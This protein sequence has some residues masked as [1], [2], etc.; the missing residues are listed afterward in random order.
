MTE[1]GQ[2]WAGGVQIERSGGGDVLLRRC[3]LHPAVTLEVARLRL[4]TAGEGYDAPQQSLQRLRGWAREVKAVVHEEGLNRWLLSVLAAQPHPL[5]EHME[6]RFSAGHVRLGVCL[7]ATNEQPPLL[8]S[9]D[10][11]PS[12]AG[13]GGDLW[14]VRVGGLRCWGLVDEVPAR[15]L[16][17]VLVSFGERFDPVTPPWQ[18]RA[19]CG[20]RWSEPQA[21]WAVSIA[22][23]L[24]LTFFVPLGWKLP[25]VDARARWVAEPGQGAL[26]LRL[27]ERGEDVDQWGGVSALAH[28]Q[29]LSLMADVDAA[30]RAGEQQRAA[31]MLADLRAQPGMER[32]SSLI[33][34]LSYIALAA[35][36][37]PRLEQLQSLLSQ[38][39]LAPAERAYWDGLLALRRR[40]LDHPLR[41]A[42]AARALRQSLLH[43]DPASLDRLY[44]LLTLA[45]LERQEHPQR[46]VAS[47]REALRD[48]PDH[49]LALRALGA[50]YASMG[51]AALLAE[52]QRRLLTLSIPGSAPWRAL[53]LSL[54]LALEDQS[55]RDWRAATQIYQALLDADPRDLDAAA[56][57]VRCL[58]A[59]GQRDAA[60]QACM[61]AAQ[62]A[63]DQPLRAA[64]LFAQAARLWL[65]VATPSAYEQA[66]IAC[67]RALSFDPDLDDA[68]RCMIDLLFDREQFEDCLLQLQRLRSSLQRRLSAA[69]AEVRARLR[70][71]LADVLRTM[72]QILLQCGREPQATASCREL[73]ALSPLDGFGLSTLE[74]LLSQSDAHGAELIDLLEAQRT[75][76]TAAH[77]R[78]RAVSLL[79]RLAPL[80]QRHLGLTERACACL[81]HALDL[82]DP[83]DA[84]AYAALEQE[85]LALL[86]EASPDASQE[87]PLLKL[88]TS[89]RWA[90]HRF[91]ALLLMSRLYQEVFADLNSAQDALSH[92]LDCCISSSMLQRLS[93]A[94]QSISAHDLHLDILRAQI[95]AT[96][97][98]AIRAPLMR[99]AAAV[100]RTHLHREAEALA[101]EQQVSAFTA[102]PTPPTKGRMLAHPNHG[103]HTDTPP[104]APTS[105]SDSA[106]SSVITFDDAP[107]ADDPFEDGPFE[108]GPFADASFADASF[109]DVSLLSPP[110]P[111]PTTADME[112]IDSIDNNDWSQF[113]DESPSR[114]LPP[115]RVAAARARS[116]AATAATASAPPDDP[117]TARQLA[118]DA[119]RA[120]DPFALRD[121]LISLIA[122]EP[123]ITTRALL[124][125]ELGCLAYFD[126]EDPNLARLHLEAALEADPDG[127]GRA[128]DTLTALE[129][130]Y[131]DLRDYEGLFSIYQHKLEQ[132][133]TSDMR[134][135][136]LVLMAQTCLRHLDQPEQAHH[137]LQEALVEAPLHE[138]A[139]RALAELEASLHHYE[140]AAEL[141]DRLLARLPSDSYEAAE[142]RLSLADLY[143]EHLDDPASAAKLLLSVVEHSATH[144]DRALSPLLAACLLIDDGPGALDAISR[145][146]SQLLL[147]PIAH[148]S[149]PLL[150]LLSLSLST[151]P[152]DVAAEVADLL[153]NAADTADRL[154]NR[155]D[156]AWRLHELALALNPDDP[157]TL[158]PAIDRARQHA[159][160]AELSDLL[161]R[162]ALV[163]L[164]PVERF[165]ALFEAAQ[166][167]LEHLD[168]P[169]RARVLLDDALAITP[170]PPPAAIAAHVIT[171]RDLY[172]Q[173]RV[174]ESLALGDPPVSA[175]PVH[176]PLM[177]APPAPSPQDVIHVSL[178]RKRS[179]APS[180]A[181]PAAPTAAVA[182]T[183]KAAPLPSLFPAPLASLPDR[184]LPPPTP[185]I[186]LTP[187]STAALALL[188][189]DSGVFDF[190]NFDTEQRLDQVSQALEQTSDIPRRVDLLTERGLLLARNPETQGD[191]LISLRAALALNPNHIPARLAM[192][193]ALIATGELE[194]AFNHF[195]ALLQRA[196]RSPSSDPQVQ[197]DIQIL[198][199]IFISTG[200]PRI[201]AR[202]RLLRDQWR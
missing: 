8:M 83:N 171:A 79:R 37:G 145:K 182:A 52:T 2:G 58:A 185:G 109:S 49:P 41:V 6:V 32:A 65:T 21:A 110:P 139:L 100:L 174:S 141:Y 128:A 78:V 178:G 121:A 46:A 59:S 17:E 152:E 57:L 53:Q 99:E 91:E 151:V 64:V 153:T 196:E 176:V 167:I 5:I 66:L 184:P 28:Q 165:D 90:A 135:V 95:D 163:T 19:R 7:R 34:R 194:Q 144:Q 123:N 11:V 14:S 126:L 22:R 156:Q 98:A 200:H 3:A 179:G 132:Q 40:D 157:A 118:A 112:E 106:P 148:P 86:R 199:E 68:H 119:R 191:A 169:V 72:T 177:G 107:F 61:R 111:P 16:H 158:D 170:N 136:Y 18:P 26:R 80:Y 129:G 173:L 85:T 35:G 187:T 75:A 33:E 30:L 56:G 162:R 140:R 60:L 168:D 92:A 15:V 29:T 195:T 150:S 122:Y 94:A 43:L 120:N 54:G 180:T 102:T 113:F 190:D 20:W 155:R 142:A 143:L 82:T 87:A 202:A 166:I 160:H 74:R 124:H 93:V 12:Q 63:T 181:S 67:Q 201:R 104:P 89:S 193:D 115:T 42:D 161:E 76:A 25:T 183:Y 192:I 108:D 88:T 188:H 147:V 71:D 103:A 4:D 24:W 70:D 197:M 149:D 159:R 164:D 198:L 175:P 31:R 138:A 114:P 62:G 51:Q 45:H 9:A 38:C 154:L 116:Q 1:H 189:D 10:I 39:A 50:V 137:L 186:S 133:Q 105:F 96:T 101:L 55:V 117:S 73:L 146:L 13:E 69:S 23:T 36:D 48:H 97:S 81:S 125:Q 44:A 47:L 77:D 27:A 130:L 84:S 127:I 134:V 172:L 131:E